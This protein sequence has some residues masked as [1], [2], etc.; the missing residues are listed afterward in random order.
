VSCAAVVAG[1]GRLRINT[2]GEVDFAPTASP[3][4]STGT[5][6]LELQGSQRTKCERFASR[7][8]A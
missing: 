1:V 6:Q 7:S 5:P 3:A 4:P 8:I 2:R